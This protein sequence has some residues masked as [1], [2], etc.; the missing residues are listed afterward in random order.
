MSEGG[1]VRVVR[2]PK[3]EKL[4]PELPDYPVY[5][6]G[7]CNATLQANNQMPVTDEL[8]LDG[9]M[10]RILEN[11]ESFSEKR[12]IVLNDRESGVVEFKGKERVL[13]ERMANLDGSSSSRTKNVEVFHD[14]GGRYRRSLKAPIDSN[15]DELIRTNADENWE[16][17]AEM[18]NAAG[19]RKSRQMHD[20][21]ATERGGPFRRTPRAVGEGVRFSPY[22]DEGPSNY[23]ASS[24]YE[25]GEAIKHPN[26]D[27]SERV[28]H[29]EQDRAK[30]LRKLDDLRDQLS[31]SCDISEE[32]KERAPPANRR[33]APL[34]SNDGH[35]AWFAEG[36]ATSNCPSSQLFP[37]NNRR[38]PYFSNEHVP[39]MNRHEMAMQN[40]YAP[41][42]L[43]NEIL[44]CGDLHGPQMPRRAPHQPCQYPQ[45]PSNGY[46]SG[47]CMDPDPDPFISYQ[48]NAFYNQP[49]CS[50]LRCYNN[51]NKHWQVPAQ[52]PPAVFCNRQLPNNATGRMLY[53]IDGPRMLGTG[54]YNRRGADAPLCSH[55]PQPHVRRPSNLDLN[56]GG[57]RRS[58][59]QGAVLTKANLRSCLPIAG[60]APFITCYNCFK[61]LQLPKNLLSLEKCQHTLRCGACFKVIS[62]A[63]DGKKLTVSFPAQTKHRS[64]DVDNDSGDMVRK[65]SYSHMNQGTMD[66][67]SGDYDNIAYNNQ[68]TDTKPVSS[69]ALPIACNNAM[70]KECTLNLSD[71]EK[72]QGLSSSSSSLEDDENPDSMVSE[73]NV[74]K[75]ME[76]PLKVDVASPTSGVPLREHFGCSP[77]NQVVSKF[78][79]GSRSKRLDQA[80]KGTS[81]QNSVKDAS[82]ATEMDCSYNEYSNSVVSPDF[83]EVKKEE[84]RAK[85]SKGGESF[86]GGLIKKSFK[87]FVRSNQSLENGKTN[88]SINGQ[89]IPDRL[90]KKAEKQ[91]GPIQPGQYWYDYRAGFWGVMGQQC[92]GIIPP[93][94]EEF[95]YPMPKKCSGGDTAVFV[96]GRELHQKDLD[97]LASRGLPVTRDK[98]YLVEISGRLLDEASGEELD[99]LGKLAPT[100]EKVK[101]GFGMRVLTAMT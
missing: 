40:S 43:E 72:M 76:L 70:G 27:G 2:C 63:L 84:D 8:S 57:F 29:L 54:S 93:F 81:R 73:R 36:S 46:L 98:S 5:R 10:V 47:Q 32:P 45:R 75:S 14:H 64:V 35:S 24:A 53:H 96:N 82:V 23:H 15:L 74:S 22:P 1:N 25:Y 91:A 41:M 69:S 62:F 4:L 50:C 89:P 68:S 6:C 99:G 67:Y 59:P 80:T 58:C 60:G 87:E 71:S 48:Q 7:G 65:G 33:T 39:L 49:P 56:M 34:T 55:E 17:E 86:F 92:L 66:S 90:V 37:P 38:P 19:F 21:R 79:K 9:E 44:G 88:V 16:M 52:V 18:E 95:N 30:L 97:L 100:V 28:E 77:N 12:G 94:I 51:Y 85:V 42:H 3:C 83:G 78:Q 61:L 26:P 101:H 13:P 20:W 11:S 31:R